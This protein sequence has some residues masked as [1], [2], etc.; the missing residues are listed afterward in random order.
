ML[1]GDVGGS[2]EAGPVGP[3][4][5]PAVP[6]AVPEAVPGSGGGRRSTPRRE[7]PESAMSS[8]PASSGRSPRSYSPYLRRIMALP[9][10]NYPSRHHVKMTAQD[11][12]HPVTSSRAVS[13][14][15]L[16]VQTVGVDRA[17]APRP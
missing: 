11:L 4:A 1:L 7:P 14:E 6:E 2:A 13:T 5:V 9:C 10:G 8:R 3:G 16:K 15:R 17:Y 12:H